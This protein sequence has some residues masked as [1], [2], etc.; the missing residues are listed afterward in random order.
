A[1]SAYSR[2]LICYYPTQGRKLRRTSRNPSS[3]GRKIQRY[4]HGSPSHAGGK[5]KANGDDSRRR[6][7]DR[8]AIAVDVAR[9]LWTADEDAHA[10]RIVHRDLRSHGDPAVVI[11]RL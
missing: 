7:H 9:S 5:K 11:R 4:M 10:A 1:G 2:F 8:S 3:N 6:R